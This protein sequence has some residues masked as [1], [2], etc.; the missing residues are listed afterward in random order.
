MRRPAL[1]I[2]A[3]AWLAAAPPAGGWPPGR[4]LVGYY[5]SW[6]VYGRDYH[7]PDIPAEKIN[8]INYAFA[9]I[10][11]GQIVLGDPYADTERWYPGDSWEPDSLRGSFHRLQIL[12]RAHPHVRTLISVGGWTWS[13]HFSDVAL[14]PASR[15]RFAASCVDF[16]RRYGFDGI[17]I[18]WEYP[19]SGG[20]PGNAYR[21]EDR[22]NYTLLLAELRAR[23]DAAGDYLLTAAAPASPLVIAN[24]EV[25]LIHPFLDWINVMTY[26]FHGPWGGELDPVTN[27]N[28]PLHPAAGDP[29]PE[30]ARS[31]FNL[32]AAVR[33]YLDLGVPPEKIHPGL[34][35]Y[36]R[37]FGQVANA[38][39][40]LFAAYQGPSWNGTWEAGVFDFWDLREHYI[41]LNGYVSHR[42]EGAGV[43]W[44]H[45]PGAGVMISYDD[46]SSIAAKGEYINAAGL[47]GA[48]F[49]EFSGDR[50]AELLDAIYA[51]IVAGASAP[52]APGPPDGWPLVRVLSAQPWCS[53]QALRLDLAL[54]APA[55]VRVALH[56]PAGRELRVLVDGPSR[57]GVRV[58]RWDGRDLPSGVYWIAASGEGRN[59]SVRVLRVR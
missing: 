11:D 21:P 34:A 14:T 52:P 39:E 54:R 57:P 20:L 12:K 13:T 15:A 8:I 18:D 22:E 23:L 48:M 44:V 7:V 55:D 10:R 40:G 36:G 53:G 30:P 49:W 38:H 45:N 59:G 25:E 31:S 6:A 58:L 43:P 19:V 46:P 5:A 2:L 51:T 56:D 9:N 24:I 47:G 3:M 17:D 33:A 1:C 29:S 27:F 41:D 26:D 4:M 35:F 50:E 37:G 42:H 16:V 28:A 32:A